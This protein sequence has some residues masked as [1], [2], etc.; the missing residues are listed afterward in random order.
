MKVKAWVEMAQEINVDVSIDDVIAGISSF[1]EP[2]SAQAA[3]PLLLTCIG[4]VMKIPDETVAAMSE[5]Q[6]KIVAGRL[7]EQAERFAV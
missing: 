4:V 5:A 6:R 7:R 3:L 2:K 1:G